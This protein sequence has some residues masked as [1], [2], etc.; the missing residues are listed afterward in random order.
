MF[1]RLEIVNIPYF[2][3]FESILNVAKYVPS[4]AP[5]LEK[6]VTEERV[7]DYLMYDMTFLKKMASFPRSSKMA[8]INLVED[9]LSY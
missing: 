7:V 9:I 8:R 3:C 4:T 6:L 1:N 5:V 2:V